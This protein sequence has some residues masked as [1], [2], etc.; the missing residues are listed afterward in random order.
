MIKTVVGETYFTTNSEKC[1]LRLY[2]QAKF[3]SYPN[4]AIDIMTMM[5]P[6]EQ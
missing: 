4:E 2:S 5:S 3:P 1:L 6:I